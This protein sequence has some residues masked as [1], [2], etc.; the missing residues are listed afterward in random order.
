LKPNLRLGWRRDEQTVTDRL[1]RLR[2]LERVQAKMQDA[3]N[4]R[5]AALTRERDELDAARRAMLA[6]AAGEFASFG[7]LAVA[8]T[9][10]MRAIEQQ[11]EVATQAHDKQLKRAAESTSRAKMAKNARSQAE[12]VEVVRRVRD[13]LTDLIEAT[14][15]ARP[16][17]SGQG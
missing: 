7:P 13:D 2:R 9:R 15:A 8:V 10:R 3:A 4:W 6:S 5:L 1:G 12:A 11:L 14:L 17:S 16:S